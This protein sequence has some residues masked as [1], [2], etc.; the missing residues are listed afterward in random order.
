MTE[1]IAA[2]EAE[3]AHTEAQILQTHLYLIKDRK[4]HQDVCREIREN[5]LSAEVAIE[6]VLRRIMTVFEQSQ[7]SLIAERAADIR[8]I[9]TR[10]SRRVSRQHRQVIETLE[11]DDP[12]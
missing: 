5:A 10:L 8:D 12:P 6:S 7:N 1:T 9:I 4:F 3:L 2:L 11:G